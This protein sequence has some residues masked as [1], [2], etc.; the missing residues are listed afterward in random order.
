MASIDNIFDQLVL[1]KV[2]KE[3][4]KYEILLRNKES[5]T[6]QFSDQLFIDSY[7]K[8][9]FNK[10]KIIDRIVIKFK[11]WIASLFGLQ[12]FDDDSNYDYIFDEEFEL[13]NIPLQ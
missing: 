5:F 4:Y 7:F 11:E 1:K 3:E 13:D 10:T 2:G 6:S 12:G 8:N 9:K